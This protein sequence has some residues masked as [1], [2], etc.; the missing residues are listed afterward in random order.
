MT[1]KIISIWDNEGASFDRYTIVT[2]VE[3]VDARGNTLL[4]CLGLSHNPT[5]PQGFSQWST[6]Q[7]GE[8]L[9]KRIT[10]EDL[11]GELQ[12]HVAKRMFAEGDI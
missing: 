2:N 10:F 7:E 12:L 11:D 3:E 4:M 8:H 1:M 9:G 5:D 6:A